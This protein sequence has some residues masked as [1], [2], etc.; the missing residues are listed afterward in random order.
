MQEYLAEEDIKKVIIQYIESK[1]NETAILINGEW[2]IGKTYF[3]ENKLIPYVESV[4][5]GNTKKNIIRISLYG[6]KDEET[7]MKQIYLKM[8][9]EYISKDKKNDIIKKVGKTLAQIGNCV[10][11]NDGTGGVSNDLVNFQAKVPLLSDFVSIVNVWSKIENY[12]L[13]FD[14]MERCEI[15]PCKVLGIVNYYLES[16]KCKCII[17]CNENEINRIRNNT[18]LEEKYMVALNDNLNVKTKLN[19]VVNINSITDEECKNDNINE[20]NKKI[21]LSELKNRMNAIFS[22][23]V[24]YNIIKEKV[25]GRTIYFHQDLKKIIENIVKEQDYTELER[26][27]ILSNKDSVMDL[28]EKNKH[29]NIRTLLC[30]FEYFHRIMETIKSFTDIE[31]DCFYEKAINDFFINIMHETVVEKINN[32]NKLK[33]FGEIEAINTQ[34]GV[35][36][37][38]AVIQK[39]IK[40]G[41]RDKD[42]IRNT[43]IKHINDLKYE[44]DNKNDPIKILP[45]MWDLEDETILEN[46][47]KMIEKLKNN[48][49]K[50][51]QYS[52]IIICL[53]NLKKAGFDN[54]NIEECVNLMK[55]NIKNMKFDDKEFKDVF[56]YD[57]IVDVEENDEYIK[58]TTPLSD[59]LESRYLENKEFEVNNCF[60][61]GDGWGMELANYYYKKRD[62]IIHSKQFAKNFDVKLLLSLIENSKTVDINN[63]RRTLNTLY[64]AYYFKVYFEADYDNLIKIK[65]GV[66]KIVANQKNLGVTKSR[67][68]ES[69]IGDLKRLF[70]QLKD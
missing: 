58:V 45:K 7:I 41:V 14:D 32:S 56:G 49:Y 57:Y 47:V 66:E 10:N 44:E 30:G 8:M 51:S 29:C 70:G 9:E 50:L 62:D 2:G 48:K 40:L 55:R 43:I 39:F 33:I 19:S 60:K 24:E 4:Y 20:N 1:N 59:L 31:E 27:I 54:I 64:G 26:K 28:L 34:F 21:D 6:I 13:V 69:L 42:S 61:K 3:I 36:K 16:K 67:A 5:K 25:I 53:I 68:L 65:D 11:K 18:N 23:N 17:V 37:G 38:F 63:F 46:Y 12:I 52:K 15:D 35:I 22:E